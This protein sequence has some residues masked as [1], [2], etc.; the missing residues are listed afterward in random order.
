MFRKLELYNHYE[1][2]VFIVKPLPYEYLQWQLQ[3]RN[4]SLVKR[5][6]NLNQEAEVLHIRYAIRR[7][8]VQLP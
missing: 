1:S 2:A 6:S 7:S 8:I 5:L 3:A 4:Q